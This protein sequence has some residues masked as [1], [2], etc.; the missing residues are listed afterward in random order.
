[1][2]QLAAKYDGKVDFVFI[3]CKEAHPIEAQSI[4]NLV[5]RLEQAR[6]FVREMNVKQRVLVDDFDPRSVQALYGSLDDSGF[7]LD[8][9]GRVVLKL[10]IASPQRVED[11]V[12]ECLGLPPLQRSYPMEMPVFPDAADRSP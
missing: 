11:A 1:M 7:V 12:R 2:E 3:Y 4:G 5:E 6:K 9:E 10:A 8:K